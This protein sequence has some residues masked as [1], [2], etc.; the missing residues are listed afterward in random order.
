MD[1]VVDRI[2][3]HPDVKH[4]NKAAAMLKRSG[5]ELIKKPRLHIIKSKK[6]VYISKISI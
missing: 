4:T 2:Q 3:S 1:E 6:H 5:K